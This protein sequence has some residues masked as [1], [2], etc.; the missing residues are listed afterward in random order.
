[1]KT[2]LF[3]RAGNAV[4]TGS[5]AMRVRRITLTTLSLVMAVS[6]LTATE[7]TTISGGSATGDPSTRGYL[8]GNTAKTAKFNG[9]TALAF[10]STANFLYVADKNNNAIG[11]ESGWNL[12]FTFA[13]LHNQPGSKLIIQ[14]VGV[15]L[16]AADN[17]YVLNQSNRFIG[18]PEVRCVR[19]FLTNVA[20]GLWG[21][22]AMVLDKTTTNVYVTAGNTVLRISRS[23]AKSTLSTI[24][25]SI[26]LLGITLTENGRLAV[27]DA[28][29]N[30]I[31]LV[32]P[33]SGSASELTG[34][35]D[36]GDHFGPSGFAQ[37]NRPY[38]IAAASGGLLVVAD[39]GNNRVKVVDAAGTVTNLYGVNWSFWVTG[40]GAY[41]GWWDG[42]VAG[43]TSTTT[44][45]VASSPGRPWESYFAEMRYTRPKPTITSFASRRARGSAT[46]PECSRILDRPPVWP[47]T[48]RVRICLS[49]IRLTTRCKSSALTTIPLRHSSTRP[50]A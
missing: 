49:L 43:E 3:R 21:A 42:T 34:F 17:V 6:A 2:T 44:S 24:G 12:H 32:D 31:L 29:R 36:Q 18:P 48:K 7:V 47:W 35:L 40:P 28:T 33:A 25:R 39:N 46:H 1:M 5:A 45:W 14:P 30:G 22:N 37:F 8:D 15:A 23:G 11:V 13:L 26:E 27:C 20:S 41:P 50:K 38:G 16:D 9:P 4:W 19:N 10:D